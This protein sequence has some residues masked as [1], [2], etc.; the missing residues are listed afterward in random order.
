MR[1]FLRDWAPVIAAAVVGLGVW[2]IFAYRASEAAH[3]Q[4]SQDKLCLFLY[5]L[6]ANAIATIGTP[7]GGAYSYYHA[8]PDEVKL[9][10]KQ[11]RAVLKQLPCRP[12]S[13]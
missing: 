13:P 11:G 4:A 7:T 12:P 1:H 5:G 9:A 8:H 10:K 3:N 2:G 6:E